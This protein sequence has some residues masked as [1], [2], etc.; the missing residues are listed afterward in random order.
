MNGRDGKN[1]KKEREQREVREKRR[2]GWVSQSSRESAGGVRSSGISG[3]TVNQPSRNVVAVIRLLCVY[4]E[5]SKRI[6][7]GFAV[8]R[9]KKGA[10]EEGDGWRESSG[11]APLRRGEISRKL[12]PA[13]KNERM[14]LATSALREKINGRGFLVEPRDGAASRLLPSSEVE[15]PPPPPPAWV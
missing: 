6:A 7:V 8:K 10:R 5:R 15:P 4:L 12:F 14:T 9:K 2:D 3:R 11:N 1:G 13:Q